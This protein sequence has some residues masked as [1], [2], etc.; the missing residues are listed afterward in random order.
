MG[1]V[2]E[3]WFDGVCE[4]K[5]PGG[6]GAY[7]I[8]VKMDGMIVKTGGGYVGHGQGISNNVS[9]Y[10]GVG[11]VLDWI[12]NERPPGGC[13]VII[14]GDSKLVIKQLSGEWKI[15]GGYYEK[16]YRRA[17]QMLEVLNERIE[18]NVR[19]EWIPREKNGECDQ[20]SKQILRDMG[21]R[22]RIQPE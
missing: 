15:H 20:Y 4:P 11:A 19:F 17:K 18:G 2:L 16:W 8:L 13:V 12:L 14:R 21:I 1:F 10:A 22:F 6:H 9:E 5:N 3:A 7:G